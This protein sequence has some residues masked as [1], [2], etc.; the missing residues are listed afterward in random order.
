MAGQDPQDI[1]S[2]PTP[3]RGLCWRMSRFARAPVV[4]AAINGDPSVPAA[5]AF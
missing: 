1:G 5:D 4:L 2:T 3:R